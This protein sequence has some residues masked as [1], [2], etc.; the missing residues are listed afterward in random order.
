MDELAHDRQNMMRKYRAAFAMG[1][2]YSWEKAGTFNERNG[3]P[4][5][6][7]KTWIGQNLT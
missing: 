2:G 1:R 7:V 6:D 3:I 5:T 4:V